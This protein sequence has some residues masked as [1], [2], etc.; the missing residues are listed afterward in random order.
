MVPIELAHN[1]L[2]KPVMTKFFSTTPAA[3]IPQCTSPISHSAPI[4]NRN[5]HIS[6]TKWCIVGYLAIALWDLWGGSIHRWLEYQWCHISLLASQ[7]IGNSTVR[8]TAGSDWHQ[9]FSKIPNSA[10]LTLLWGEWPVDSPHKGL[11][12]A[13]H[14]PWCVDIAELKKVY[15]DSW[16]TNDG[17][18][19][20]FCIDFMWRCS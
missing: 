5:V 9:I 6:V 12:I 1:A 7:T 17:H 14:V 18:C 2:Y 11:V 4:C 13:E 16:D 19:F 8:S 3:Q 10:L 15:E 20:P